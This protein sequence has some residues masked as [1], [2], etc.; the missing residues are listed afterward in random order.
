MDPTKGGEGKLD[1]NQAEISPRAGGKL[2]VED[3][4]GA[5]HRGLKAKTGA[6][7]RFTLHFIP[8]WIT[9]AFNL[10]A[11]LISLN[12]IVRM[13]QNSGAESLKQ[14]VG[15]RPLMMHTKRPG[16]AYKSSCITSGEGQRLQQAVAVHPGQAWKACAR[17]TADASLC[18]CGPPD[19]RCTSSSSAW[20]STRVSRP[21]STLRDPWHQALS[22]R[23][24]PP[25]ALSSSLTTYPP[26]NQAALLVCQ[27]SSIISVC[28]C[29]SHRCKLGSCVWQSS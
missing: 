2:L 22:R 12:R 11:T 5:A 9:I 17:W 26:M 7:H 19:D 14:Q 10:A 21:E 18:Q 15:S 13:A 24:I 6:P 16:A 20:S 4:L 8:I 25:T 1:R 29:F 23:N 3:M 28:M 27:S